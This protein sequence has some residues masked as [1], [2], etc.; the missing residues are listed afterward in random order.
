MPFSLFL[1]AYYVLRKHC[2]ATKHQIDWLGRLKV[3]ES[4]RI[5]SK[6]IY[7]RNQ[8]KQI[9]CSTELGNAAINILKQMKHGR[10]TWLAGRIDRVVENHLS[11]KNLSQKC[12]NIRVIPNSFYTLI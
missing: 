3:M 7:K 1:L 10:I 8:I 5:N 11:E 2:F 4:R 9:G 6:I 12:H